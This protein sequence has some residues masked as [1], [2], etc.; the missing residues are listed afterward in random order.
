MSYLF[1]GA[2]SGEQR[3]TRARKMHMERSEAEAMVRRYSSECTVFRDAATRTKEADHV[4]AFQDAERRA[5]DASRRL[6]AIVSHHQRTGEPVGDAP[7][8]ID[9][10]AT[11]VIRRQLAE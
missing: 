4:K 2:E 3:S 1:P 7:L 9:G 10:A 6:A 8:M 11:K 5:T